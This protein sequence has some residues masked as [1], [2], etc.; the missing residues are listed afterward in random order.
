MTPSMQRKHLLVTGIVQGVGFRPWV[1]R[2]AHSL[3]LT[4]WVRNLGS[5]LEIEFEGAI[6][7]I[8]IAVDQLR[9]SPPLHATIE[10]IALT[11]LPWN[12][13]NRFEILESQPASSH[14]TAVAPDLGPCDACVNEL[15]DPS[16]RRY[17]YPWI[18]CVQCGPRYSIIQSIPYDRANTSMRWFP[19]C[20]DCRT[21]YDDP[22]DRRYRAEG[23]ACHACGPSLR[24]SWS[25]CDE[26]MQAESMPL[27]DTCQSLDGPFRFPA[28]CSESVWAMV[29]QFR[30]AIDQGCIVAVQGI[31]GYQLLCDAN[32]SAAVARLRS[33][34]RREAK[35]FA[36]MVA[37][38]DDAA[39]LIELSAA[40]TSRVLSPER[41]ILV[42]PRLHGARQQVCPN[43]SSLDDTLGV[44]LPSSP[45]HVL[46]TQSVQRPLVITSGNAAEE[47]MAVRR[48][49]AHLRLATIAD[50][51]LEHDRLIVQS[52]DDSVFRVRREL[53]IPIRRGR[54]FAPHAFPR[55]HG[56]PPLATL[57]GEWKSTLCVA[58]DEAI[59]LSQHLGDW[60]QPPALPSM[61]Q[62]LLHLSRLF[63][64]E[65][66]KI[67][68]DHH[69][70]YVSSTW[71]REH[72]EATSTVGTTIQHHHAHLASLAAEHRWPSDRPLLGFVFDGTGFGTDG[73]I[74]G[75][76]VL[77]L[78]GSR[79]QRLAHSRR[80]DLL[81]GDGCAKFPYRAALSLLRS[82]GMVLSHD[83]P[84]VRH[85]QPIEL[86]LM[87]NPNPNPHIHRGSSSFGRIIDAVA[88]LLDLQ[89]INAFEGHAALRLE[90]AARSAMGSTHEWDRGP[91]YRFLVSEADG[92]LTFD[93]ATAIRSMLIDRERGLPAAWCALKF[94]ESVV[95][96][97]VQVIEHLRQHH[98]FDD[99][100]LTGGVFQ[101]LVLLELALPQL[102]AAGVRVWTHRLVPPNDAGLSLG[103]AYALAMAHPAV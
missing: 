11:D 95:D 55:P 56:G 77:W 58:N 90:A 15:L 4:G 18:S 91:K 53:E 1:Y 9:R 27:Q 43:V 76:E 68:V 92:L 32:Q 50:A 57:G 103:Q 79:C 46:L 89:H 40:G 87:A 102:A 61:A 28:T 36:V 51:F 75:G 69:P 97:M 13:S 34:K 5:S 8:E 31:G 14:Y 7:Q 16:N 70:D 30:Q 81:G 64:I 83:I 100:G 60:D 38:I 66:S 39:E 78:Q 101:N 37:S 82:Y 85:A 74:W 99:V 21:E 73:T 62:C 52:C 98:P 63:G 42:A 2:L 29:A 48:D 59:I 23:I 86:E 80:V 33:R 25:M 47:P 54:G 20:A 96:M 93:A 26:P 65:P 12:G 49:Q 72:A 10:R 24:W 22:N 88:S 84:S 45:L 19:M 71:G 44:M 6:D 35:P 3:S 94:H 41:P 17:A 67:G